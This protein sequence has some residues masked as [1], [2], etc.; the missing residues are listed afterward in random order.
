[1]SKPNLNALN[2]LFLWGIL[3]PSQLSWL[4]GVSLS[5]C[6]RQLHNLVDQ[7]LAV[8]LGRTRLD[9]QD[10][11][12]GRYFR[13]ASGGR[14]RKIFSHAPYPF[15]MGRGP[16]GPG[17]I[18]SFSSGVSVPRHSLFSVHCA[19]WVLD[20]LARNFPDKSAVGFPESYLRRKLGWH[21]HMG[22]ARS[23]SNPKFTMVPDSLVIFAGQELKIEAELTPKSPK[24]YKELFFAARPADDNIFYIYPDG[25]TMTK[26]KSFVPDG[27]RVSHCVFGDGEALLDSIFRLFPSLS[28]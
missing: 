1:M 14:V 18:V 7:R 6:S 5:L 13:I 24:A 16:I 17:K 10:I 15:S 27:Y 9:P 21:H 25:S 3:S 23:V 28:E 4:T 19:A 11:L 22:P 26:V 12:Y 8:D 2:G 20:F